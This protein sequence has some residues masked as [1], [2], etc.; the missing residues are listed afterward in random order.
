M[1][2]AKKIEILQAA[3]LELVRHAKLNCPLL[4]RFSGGLFGSID[5]ESEPGNELR[6]PSQSQ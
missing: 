3:K 2:N 1:G 4:H 6:V 5:M